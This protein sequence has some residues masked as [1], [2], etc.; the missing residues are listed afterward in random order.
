MAFRKGSRAVITHA[1]L[2][3]FGA[4]IKL[5]HCLRFFLMRNVLRFWASFLSSAFTRSHRACRSR[6]CQSRNFSLGGLNEGASAAVARPRMGGLPAGA[7]A[8]PPSCFDE[9]SPNT[10]LHATQRFKSAP[11]VTRTLTVL[12]CPFCAAL[13]GA[14]RAAQEGQRKMSQANGQTYLMR[15][16]NPTPSV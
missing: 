8:V 4:S 10:R 11:A 3:V 14:T 2:V 1:S 16:V 5:L 13:I 15:G 6:N 7:V 12:T 9:A